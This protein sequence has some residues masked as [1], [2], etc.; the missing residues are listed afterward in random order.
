[1]PSKS[2]RNL[3]LNLMVV[4]EAI[5]ASGNISH[6]ATHLG[7]TQPAVSNALARLRGLMDDPLFVRAKRGVAPTLK[8]RRTIGP[9]RDALK[10]I[11]KQIHTGEIDFATYERD[12][13]IILADPLEP[14]V[15]PPVI[16][17]IVERM[18][19]VTL[20]CLTG[21]RTNFVEE[22][23][24][25]TVDL[26]CFIFPILRPDIITEPLGEM[27]VVIVAR[28][29]HPAFVK[30]ITAAEF[31]KLKHIVLTPELRSV[32]QA[33]QSMASQGTS[34]K[35]TYTVS[36]LWSFPP[37]IERTDL[38]GI[39]PRWFVQE[40]SRNFEIE[41]HEMPGPLSDQYFY[42]TYH[43]RNVDDAGHRWLRESITQAFRAKTGSA[44]TAKPA[45]T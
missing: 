21:Y 6:A 20:E 26:A 15:M 14:I 4:F 39:L 36:K 40:V 43:T 10:L 27:D 3:D 42:L 24:E 16:K 29:G 25:G 30:K 2:L 34:R 22:I 37:M 35:G 19:G 12:F 18:P 45:G 1:M 38:V 9:I 17:T 33:D 31:A 44:A 41:A 13:R 11:G 32:V 7:M 5:Y 8:A 23:V 28:K